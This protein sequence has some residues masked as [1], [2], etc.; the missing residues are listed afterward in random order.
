MEDSPCCYVMW[1]RR[2]L[3]RFPCISPGLSV[4]CTLPLKDPEPPRESPNLSPKPIPKGR[5]AETLMTRIAERVKVKSLGAHPSTGGKLSTAKMRRSRV[6]S[7]RR[8]RRSLAV[9]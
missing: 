1:E 2:L 5:S 6:W 8:P 3:A 7:Q 4:C 9:T